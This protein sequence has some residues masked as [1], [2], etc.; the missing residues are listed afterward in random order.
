VNPRL[1]RPVLRYVLIGVAV[2]IGL[3]WAT[4]AILASRAGPYLKARVIRELSERFDSTVELG[5]FHV[6]VFPVVRMTG[7]HLVM[8][9]EGEQALP[10]FISVG[11]FELE[12]TPLGLL[13][14][15]A[16]IGTV[17]VIGLSITLPP[18][19]QRPELKGSRKQ[20]SKTLFVIGSVVCDATRLEIMTDKPGKLP[21]IF[22]IHSLVLH[23][24][25]PGRSMP[26]S[27]QLV[28]PIPVGDIDIKG[29]FG[30]WQTEEPRDT[31]ISGTFSFTHAD[32]ATIHGIGGMLSSQGGYHGVI[33]RIEVQGKTDTPDFT[34]ATGGHPMP[35][36]T[37]YSATVDG[38]N[39]D[40]Y[41]HPVKATLLHSL[42]IANGS[43]IRKNDG[44]EI[45][46]DVVATDAH[47]E[48][49]LSVAVK[50]SPPTLSGPVS[51]KTKLLLPPGSRIVPDRLILDGEF[52]LPAA[53][54]SDAS[55]Q[56]KVDQ[57]SLRAQGRA[58]EAQ[59]E[60][61]QPD[62]PEV[63][64]ELRGKFKL[65][66]GVVSM[67][68]LNFKVP[69][70]TVNLSGDYHLT[71]QE[72]LFRGDARF[73]AKLS[74]MTT[75]VKSFLLKAADPF[76]EK[77]SAGTVLPIRISGTGTSPSVRLD[78]RHATRAK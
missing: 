31:P 29:E 62:H 9:R 13:R 78:F 4:L 32:L 44:R 49:M 35:L 60:A 68:E 37:E 57:L 41:L 30:P 69:G 59:Q 65:K 6:S 56:E 39:G 46:L 64:S 58:K 11:R 50:T 45:S 40:T 75:G 66:D 28:E 53:Y 16:S 8:R 55:E 74:Q 76:F 18:R 2:L 24:A 33:D 61:K 19:G 38:S 27:A 72:F 26:F 63:L 52:S 48:D 14:V 21:L 23:S 51:L 17:H 47:I 10:P 3:G 22:D 25:G 54:F 70:A 20:P 5:D 7:E 36:H 67:A 71:G 43:V 1:K 34:V 42:I 77:N 12:S 15:P 73:A